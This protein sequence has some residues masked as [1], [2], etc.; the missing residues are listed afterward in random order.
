[1]RHYAEAL[2]LWRYMMANSEIAFAEGANGFY[3][4]NKFINDSNYYEQI[5]EAKRHFLSTGEMLPI[6]RAH[7]AEAWR[8]DFAKCYSPDTIYNPPMPDSGKLQKLQSENKLMIYVASSVIDTICRTLTKI[9]FSL[10]LYD[11]HGVLL[12]LN[13]EQDPHNHWLLSPTTKIGVCATA[14]AS[15]NAI[16]LALC[17][18]CACSV[19]GTEHYLNQYHNSTNCAV[20]IHDT[21]GDIISLLNISYLAEARTELLASLAFIGA[22]LIEQQMQN[23]SYNS[24]LESV[25]E[26]MNDRVIVIDSHMRITL[27]NNRFRDMLGESAIKIIGQDISELFQDSEFLEALKTGEDINFPDVTLRVDGTAYR[28]SI[29]CNAMYSE[30]VFTGFVLLCQEVQ[31]I[32]A[33]SQKYIPGAIM[34][35]NSIITESPEMKQLIH[36]C[37]TAAKTDASILLEGESGTGKELFAQAIHNASSRKEHPFVAIN[38]AAIPMSLIESELFGYE[39]GSFTGA[40]NTGKV[41]KFEQANH[42]TLF[43]DEIGDLPLDV[44]GKLLRVLESH[45][46]LRIGAKDETSLDIRIVAATNRNLQEMVD[47]HNFRADLFYRLNVM[48]FAIPPLRRRYGDIQLLAEYFL[49]SLNRENNTSKY[50]AEDT[51]LRMNQYFWRGNV[52]ELQN[53]IMRAYHMCSSQGSEEITYHHLILLDTA[54]ETSRKLSSSVSSLKSAERQII[55]QTLKANDGNIKNA[56]K[57]L[58]MPLSTMYKRIKQYEINVYRI[59]AGGM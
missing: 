30:S 3:L 34:E 47:S 29:K 28:L 51:I 35:F 46:V 12:Y 13:N 19:Y 24:V 2:T 56:A 10:Q 11:K 48:Y 25:F 7:I 22:N 18:R 55:E 33:L 21:N 58:D 9:D 17:H 59:R 38:C 27:A 5:R 50:F 52:R 20:P 4:N 57:A 26:N 32:V 14:G 40:L 1:M 37:A 41:G 31:K 53:A 43:L 39:K 49:N 16:S 42:G 45:K 36:Y 6:V 54:D 15:T 23:I 8:N 44:Q